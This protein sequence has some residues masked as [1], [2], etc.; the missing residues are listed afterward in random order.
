MSDDINKAYKALG[1]AVV[2]DACEE[3]LENALRIHK[4]E[5]K[6]RVFHLTRSQESILAGLIGRNLALERFIMSDWGETLSG[7]DGKAIVEKLKERTSK[8]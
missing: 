6:Q 7:L 2:Q 4:L 8:W 3:W 1:M 5:V